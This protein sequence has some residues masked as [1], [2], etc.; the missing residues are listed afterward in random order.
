MDEYIHLDDLLNLLRGL[1]STRLVD[2]ICDSTCIVNCHSKSLSVFMFN[3]LRCQLALTIFWATMSTSSCLICL[4]DSLLCPNFWATMSMIRL[5]DCFFAQ[6]NFGL[7][8]ETLLDS[9][10]DGLSNPML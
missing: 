9:L 7:G 8:K 2:H 3:L 5:I 1:F 4:D 10:V 6:S